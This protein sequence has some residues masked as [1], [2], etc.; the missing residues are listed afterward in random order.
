MNYDDSD[1]LSFLLK[2][3]KSE[4]A[5]VKDSLIMSIT[6]WR[7]KRNRMEIYHLQ[8]SFSIPEIKPLEIEKT[9]DWG[10]LDSKG[11]RQTLYIKNVVQPNDMLLYVTK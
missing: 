3:K 4:T 11:I 10:Q 1:D 9:I 5:Q 7:R 2:G 8:K 6:D